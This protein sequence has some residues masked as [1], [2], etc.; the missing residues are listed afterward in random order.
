MRLLAEELVE[1]IR[2]RLFMDQQ[3]WEQRL[4]TDSFLISMVILSNLQL[5]DG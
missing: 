2:P 5:I 4:A 3:H 1:R